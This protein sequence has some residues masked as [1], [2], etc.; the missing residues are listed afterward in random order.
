VTIFLQAKGAMRSPTGVD[1]PTRTDP[2][3]IEK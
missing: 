3:N 2:K 1:K